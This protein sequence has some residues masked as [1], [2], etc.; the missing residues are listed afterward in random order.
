MLPAISPSN[1]SL[2]LAT[3]FF[4]TGWGNHLF[5]G[6]AIPGD[7]GLQIVFSDD[8]MGGTMIEASGTGTTDD[9]G[10]GI[11]P[12]V[13]FSDAPE[14]IPSD[15]V[16]PL[17]MSF[18]TLPDLGEVPLGDSL[19]LNLS[20][21]G[22]VTLVALFSG[23]GDFGLSRNNIDDVVSGD[24]QNLTVTDGT[25]S[26][27]IDYSTFS[28]F[29]G[30]SFPSTD[31][32]TFVFS[33][34]APTPAI[35][36]VSGSP[37]IPDLQ[38]GKKKSRLKGDDI[39]DKRKASNKQTLVQQRQIFTTNTA[40][41]ALLM[42]NDGGTAAEMKLTSSGDQLPRMK[43]RARA[44]GRGNI[45]A[46]LKRSGFTATVP[47]GGSIAISYKLKTERFFAGVI[48]NGD[49][50]DTIRFRLSGNGRKD[51]AAMIVKYQD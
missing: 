3:A 40:K 5:A 35:T 21:Y 6:A 10:M 32:F 38:I 8:G 25:G 43:V 23:S 24:S 30:L 7:G 1:L 4:I 49:R 13:G 41:A 18:P 51:N 20:N 12:G 44:A 26:V 42:Q 37:A 28:A 31:G 27:P 14:A 11:S 33:P 45:T 50:D 16:E 46:A 29:H 15:L 19:E 17:P 34:P 22:T 9:D 48:R 2:L 47:A 39:Y 36:P